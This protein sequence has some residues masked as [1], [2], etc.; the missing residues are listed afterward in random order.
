MRCGLSKMDNKLA[1]SK[2]DNK[3]VDSPGKYEL[4]LYECNNH[5]YDACSN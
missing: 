1:L 3:G 4:R 5:H 2:M